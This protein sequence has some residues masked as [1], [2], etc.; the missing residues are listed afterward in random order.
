MLLE[1]SLKAIP[2]FYIYGEMLKDKKFLWSLVFVMVSKPGKPVNSQISQLVSGPY[3]AYDQVTRT[4]MATQ[5]LTQPNDMAKIVSHLNPIQK[6]IFQAL[7]LGVA[8]LFA[9][10]FLLPYLQQRLSPQQLLEVAL[11]ILAL[12]YAFLSTF[13][14]YFYLLI[15]MPFQVKKF[16]KLRHNH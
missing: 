11:V 1:K 10:L 3:I 4:I 14:E 16:A 9:N 6:Q 12:S 15:G 7:L 8:T 5:M 2:T 13:T